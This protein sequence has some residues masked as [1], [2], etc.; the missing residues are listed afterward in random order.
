M[1]TDQGLR[2]AKELLFLR[3]D[4]EVQSGKELLTPIANRSRLAK[5]MK[6]FCEEVLAKRPKMAKRSRIAKRQRI[7]VLAKRSSIAKR[8][9][10]STIAKSSRLPKAMK[11]SCEEVLAKGSMIAKR[12]RISKR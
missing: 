5:A 6:N 7:D 8:S 9:K 10:K 3:R 11:N 12:S 1:Q 4:Q 2:R